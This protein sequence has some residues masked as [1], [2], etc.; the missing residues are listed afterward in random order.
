MN[1]EMNN[2]IKLISEMLSIYQNTVLNEKDLENLKLIK[3]DIDNK[4]IELDEIKKDLNNELNTL[5]ENGANE[6]DPEINQLQ[7]VINE[8]NELLE[9]IIPDILSYINLFNSPKDKVVQIKKTVTN[10]ENNSIS[11]DKQTI[12]K[13][14]NKNSI[15]LEKKSEAKKNEPQKT[16]VKNNEEDKV[17]QIQQETIQIKNAKNEKQIENDE[18][19]EKLNEDKVSILE[20][21]PEEE[22]YIAPRRVVAKKII[23]SEV[24]IQKPKPKIT[25][26]IKE[27]TI[28]EETK[29]PETDFDNLNNKITKKVEYINTITIKQP[30]DNYK[31]VASNIVSSRQ[32]NCNSP[33]NAIQK[34]HNAAESVMNSIIETWKS[35]KN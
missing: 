12:I 28:I 17:E 24:P 23:K 3:K 29:K 11:Q 8:V 15:S 26:Q 18:I 6:I 22:L 25:E 1:Q 31:N 14:N 2:K 5:Y 19:K 32:K 20:E 34:A 30:S 35:K 27:A 10:V 4:K 16:E 13:E 7:I 9:D 21:I 33:E